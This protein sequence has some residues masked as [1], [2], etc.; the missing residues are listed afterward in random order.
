MPQRFEYDLSHQNLVFGELGRLRCV[1]TIPVFAGDRI[2]MSADIFLRFS[3]F[4][5]PMDFGVHVLTMI[6]Y[7]PFIIA[8]GALDWN[9]D[10]GRPFSKWEQLFMDYTHAKTLTSV[11]DD[12]VILALPSG[13]KWRVNTFSVGVGGRVSEVASVDDPMGALV[14]GGGYSACH[15]RSYDMVYDHYFRDTRLEAPKAQNLNGYSRGDINNW[16]P[17]LKDM[18][19]TGSVYFSAGWHDDYLKGRP[20]FHLADY[21]TTGAGDDSNWDYGYQ[22][23]VIPTASANITTMDINEAMVKDLFVRETEL[24]ADRYRDLLM[25]MFGGNTPASSE[26]RPIILAENEAWQ[27]GADVNGT[28]DTNLGAY[29]GKSAQVHTIG[30]PT[31]FFPQHGFI[32]MFIVCRFPPFWTNPA[33]SHNFNP[34]ANANS[35][36]QALLLPEAAGLERYSAAWDETNETITDRIYNVPYGQNARSQ[37]NFV[38]PVFARG[39]KPLY[40]VMELDSVPSNNVKCDPDAWGSVFQSTEYGHWNA[41]IMVHMAR[42]T[43]V[44]PGEEYLYAGSGN[45]MH[46]V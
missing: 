41:R 40:P 31:R 10:Y 46:K 24:E 2:H 23:S 36:K 25:K 5:R 26:F 18:T 1:D 27:T 33:R 19:Q 38:D 45:D 17:L 22:E 37:P 14:V 32:Q 30:F 12:I 15:F 29:T 9:S 34:F 8:S 20:V 42:E 4:R 16:S 3:V 13:D 6:T 7:T 21:Y 44:R 43:V 28:G 39:T 35:F 11:Q